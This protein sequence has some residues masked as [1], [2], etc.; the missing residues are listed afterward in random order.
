MY[1]NQ[2]VAITIID[3]CSLKNGFETK[4]IIKTIILVKDKNIVLYS[5]YL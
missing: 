4:K 1:S 3:S 5:I 2:N